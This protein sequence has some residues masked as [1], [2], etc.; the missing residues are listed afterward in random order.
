MIKI[1][2][3]KDNELLEDWFDLLL[4]PNEVLL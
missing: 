2:V 3:M 1:I 4:S